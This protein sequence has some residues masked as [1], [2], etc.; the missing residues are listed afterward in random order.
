M[1]TNSNHPFTFLHIG[2]LIQSAESE[3]TETTADGAFVPLV[4]GEKQAKLVSGDIC[5]FGDNSIHWNVVEPNTLK[6]KYYVSQTL[7][8]ATAIIFSI[9]VL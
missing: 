5:V 7:F 3:E 6:T 4:D 9:W 2:Q 8:E 1:R